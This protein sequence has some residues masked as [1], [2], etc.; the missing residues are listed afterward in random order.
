MKPIGGYFSLELRNGGQYYSDAV[1]LNSARSCLEYILRAKKYSKIYIPYYSCDVILQT[2]LNL[3]IDYDFYGIDQ[4]FEIVSNVTVRQNECLLYINYFGLKQSYTECLAE[5]YGQNLIVDNSQAFYTGAIRGTD[6]FYSPR[7][8]FG[9]SDGGILITEASYEEHLK[10]DTSYNRMSH[11]LKRI[12]IG[13]EAA[14]EDFKRNEAALDNTGI[15]RMSELSFRIL[16]SIDYEHAASVRK[17][18]FEFL[19]S[20][21][22]TRNAINFKCDDNSV[23]MVYPYYCEDDKLRNKLIENKIFVATYWPNVF[24]WCKKDDIEYNLAK[25][26]LPLPIDQRYGIEEMEKVL[27]VVVG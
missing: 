19:H 24:T 14:Y 6:T 12:D 17:A 1:Y 20:E 4:S 3:G 13:P 25:H 7:K 18:N 11:L 2:V 5:H 15:F 16:S 10:P 27:E 21:L 26:I 23:P 8:F 9:V 22:K